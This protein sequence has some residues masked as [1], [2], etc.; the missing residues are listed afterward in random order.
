M[1]MIKSIT[2]KSHLFTSHVCNSGW[3]VCNSG[4]HVC[5][6]GWHVCNFSI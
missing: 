3:N 2:T 6:S 1:S 5:S 4:W